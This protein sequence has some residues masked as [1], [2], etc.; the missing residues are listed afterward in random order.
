[1]NPTH[2]H[3]EEW[4][5]AQLERERRDM[6]GAPWERERGFEPRVAP[7]TYGNVPYEAFAR[8]NR[9]YVWRGRDEEHDFWGFARQ[10]DH[11]SLWERVK[12]AFHG[13]G[14]KNY[15]RADARIHEDACERLSYHPYID[16]SDIEV[17][18]R[19]GEVTLS[20]SVDARIVKRAA[21]DCVEHV[22]GVK[23]VHNHLRVKP[24]KQ[25]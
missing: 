2:D 12:G 10:A 18:V 23:D 24:R 11:P 9:P 13:K 16:A 4:R 15:V 19:D 22:R 25:A 7:T 14:P 17:T 5:R 20:G 8:E 1:M 21:E 3:D 6:R